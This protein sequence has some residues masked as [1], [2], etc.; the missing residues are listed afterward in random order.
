[1][2][3]P[4]LKKKW[5]VF[6]A[7]CLVLSLFK[8]W[9]I[10]HS[11]IVA[12]YMPHDQSWFLNA[13]DN[14]LAGRWLGPYDSMTLIRQAGYPLWIASVHLTGL[15]LRIASELLLLA[16]AG[17]FS[18]AWTKARLP[19]LG[20]VAIFAAI[21][22]H[23]ASIRVT[24]E[25]ESETLYTPALIFFLAGCLFLGASSRLRS[26]LGW[27]IFNGFWLAVLWNTRHEN[28][29]LL[30]FLFFWAA[31]L[32]WLDGRRGVLGHNW[33]SL[34]AHALGI[35]LLVV[36]TSVFF[37]RWA[38]LQKYGLFA[39]S[40]MFAPGFSAFN[41]A[42]LEIDAGEARSYVPIN[43]AMRRA[44]YAVSPLV[45]KIEKPFE[46]AAK[47]AWIAH[48]C[49]NLGVC[50]DV[51]GGLVVWALRD[52][53]S[54][55]GFH[56]SG[57]KAEEFYGRAATELAQACER[58][59]IRCRSRPWAT[60]GFVHPEFSLNFRGIAESFG[61]IL[62]MF[63]ESDQNFFQKDNPFSTAPELRQAYDRV[64]NRRAAWTQPERVSL[65][66][67]T[68]VEGW[69]YGFQDPIIR[70]AL[71]DAS[72]NELG[73]WPLQVPRPDVRQ[74]LMAQGVA[75]PSLITGFSFEIDVG[76]G[77]VHADLVFARESNRETV[78]PLAVS[79]NFASTV[80]YSIDTVH[81]PSI[82]DFRK[83]AALWLGRNYGKWVSVGAV[84]A[85]LALFLTLTCRMRQGLDPLFLGFSALLSFVVL[86]RVA[87]FTVFDASSAKLNVGHVR[88]LYPVV[89]IFSSLIIAWIFKIF[90]RILGEVR[91]LWSKR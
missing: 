85:L 57:E 31:I 51:I 39:T 63:T 46:E 34:A 38:N 86:T 29:L 67:K 8:L 28:I 12:R 44:A 35:P 68:R 73:A 43:E 77:P 79:S 50:D 10:G 72:R 47:P 61:N 2:N 22:L 27:S 70:V 66:G 4:I 90:P 49:R 18:I 26:S 40:E 23:P 81:G 54:A 80:A 13:A 53:V 48:G 62:K 89:G 37:M 16:S 17:V 33:L 14:I 59:R 69:A 83:E 36:M 87:L 9:L 71:R 88:Y 55:A 19:L 3:E 76:S 65:S 15:P 82:R 64:A 84:L 52:A 74:F 5:F 1:M 20:A 24:N 41:R 21:A 60:L 75:T 42:L 91:I 32:F 58:G 78:V 11:E 25:M 6:L 7:S 30:F 56:S 45:R